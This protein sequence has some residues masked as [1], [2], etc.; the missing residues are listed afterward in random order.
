MLRAN[1]HAGKALL[2][3]GADEER[4]G[5]IWLPI[6]P[7]DERMMPLAHLE[8]LSED[9]EPH[10]SECKVLCSF[11]LTLMCSAHESVATGIDG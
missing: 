4:T 7:N 11:F 8:S 1:L 2:V 6:A 9:D 10:A 5:H 3:P